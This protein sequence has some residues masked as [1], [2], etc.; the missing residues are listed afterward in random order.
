MCGTL[1]KP[2]SANMCVDCLRSQVDITEGIPKQLTVQW[3]K[4]CGRYHQPPT[5]WI[6]APLESPRLLTLCLKKLRGL[7]KVKLV[8]AGFV[9]TE[10]HSRRLKVK[11][12]IEREV[13]SSTILRQSFV[14]EYVV[15][16]LQCGDC[17]KLQAQ[18]TWTAV[19][20][21]RQKVNHKRTFF[22]VEQ[23]IL[24]HHA[25]VNTINIKEFPDGLDFYFHNRSHA[26]KFVEFLQSIIPI[27]YVAAQ[28]LISHDVKSNIWN[29]KYTYSVEIAPICRDDLLCIPK[30][31]AKSLGNIHPLVLCHKVANNLRFVDP[32]Q[33]QGA[34]IT[35]TC[36]W[37]N[38][39]RSI[40][41][42]E[43]L[44][45]YVV[46][47]IQR[48]S[49]RKSLGKLTLCDVQV[50]RA[51]DFGANDTVFLGRTHLGHLLHPGDSAMGYDLTSAVFNE[52]DLKALGYGGTLPD[53]VLV[54][55]HYPIRNRKA[56]R[57]RHWQLK[58]LKKE[59]VETDTMSTRAQRE[60]EAR[61]LD[62]YEQFL[63]EIEEDPELRSRLN[64]YKTRNAESIAAGRKQMID[65]EGGDF[66][67][68]DLC[69]LMGDMDLSE[70][71]NRA[72]TFPSSDD[73][74][75]I[76]SMPSSSSDVSRFSILSDD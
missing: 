65:E 33:L 29:Y 73:E 32:W 14:V 69:E 13:F 47:D 5:A 68:V 22:L 15:S 2:N 70:R 45:E 26:I 61:E 16:G 9:W 18:N 20:Q 44:V 52:S 34:E 66:P 25:H 19:A 38:Q 28:K 41:T 67:E 58:T 53:F 43:Q 27:R 17:Q 12:T 46:L 36:F 21:V 76:N 6:D 37:E 35:P 57:S 40:A 24:K 10:P 71:S 31:L 54:K 64:L 48:H 72:D 42:R 55:K 4:G 63:Q 49:S 60:A 50:A 74:E 75:E 8:D 11:L 7:N 56:S 51:R 23:L 39:F 3:C 59:K 30:G 62:Q 1:I